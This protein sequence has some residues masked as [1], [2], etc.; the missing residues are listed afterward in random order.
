MLLFCLTAKAYLSPQLLV[1]MPID[2]PFHCPTCSFWLFHSD[3]PFVLT[4]PLTCC[5]EY[6]QVN[7][8]TSQPVQFVCFFTCFY[9]HTYLS[10]HMLVCMSV[11]QT[12]PKMNVPVNIDVS[13]YNHEDLPADSTVYLSIDAPVQKL[14]PFIVMHP[15]WFTSAIYPSTQL[16][17]YIYT[18]LPG[19]KS[20]SL[21]WCFLYS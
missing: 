5:S 1:Y 15:F 16:L 10:T 21:S 19:N 9:M 14:S 18:D 12:H 4:Y 3:K 11:R 13:G 20:T 6:S 2:L 7:L 8:F 17:L